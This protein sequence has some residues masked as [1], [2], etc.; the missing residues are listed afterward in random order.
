MRFA[1]LANFTGVPAI[2]FPVGY[3]RDGLPVCLQVMGR[4]WDE[5]KLLKCVAPRHN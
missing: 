5:D 1:F 4:W 3:D 2:T